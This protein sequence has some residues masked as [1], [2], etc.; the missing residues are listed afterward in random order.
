MGAD[1]VVLGMLLV[2]DRVFVCIGDQ[3]RGMFEMSRVC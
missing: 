2:L 3:Y 1:G